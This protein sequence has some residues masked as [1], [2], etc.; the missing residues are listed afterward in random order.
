MAHWIESMN[1][2]I[3]LSWFLFAHRSQTFVVG[4]KVFVWTF[5]FWKALIIIKFG[6]SSFDLNF[7]IVHI[8]DIWH[9]IA[10]YSSTFFFVDMALDNFQAVV[11]SFK[12]F[13]WRSSARIFLLDYVYTQLESSPRPRFFFDLAYCRFQ[14]RHHAMH[15]NH[16]QRKWFCEIPT[17]DWYITYL[18]RMFLKM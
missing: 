15:T 3:R 11:T 9:V 1:R 10:N 8:L 6:S 16:T 7:N 12:H 14:S 17:V 5:C 13:V 4:D 2:P 18:N